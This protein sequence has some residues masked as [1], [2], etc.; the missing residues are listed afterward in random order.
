LLRASLWTSS[1]RARGSKLW[2]FLA[3]GIKKSKAKHRG[4]QV[5]FWTT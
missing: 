5:G 3:N 2:R 1:V 4:I